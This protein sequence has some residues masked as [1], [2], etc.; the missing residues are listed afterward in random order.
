MPPQLGCLPWPWDGA[1]SSCKVGFLYRYNRI[2]RVT[3]A[4][5]LTGNERSWYNLDLS[6]AVVRVG[7]PTRLLSE[8]SSNITAVQQETAGKHDEKWRVQVVLAAVSCSIIQLAAGALF[9]I[10]GGGFYVVY[11]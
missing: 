2:H 6:I 11:I 10:Y 4:N 9:P 3:D 8:L 7:V 1:H 5:A